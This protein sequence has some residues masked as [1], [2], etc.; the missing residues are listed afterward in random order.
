MKNRLSLTALL[1]SA[2]GLVS[3]PRQ[4]PQQAPAESARTQ[5]EHTHHADLQADIHT[6]QSLYQLESKWQTHTG[7]TIHLSTL[8]GQPQVL[9]MVYAS[10]KNACP[11][12]IADMKRIQTGSADFPGGVRY[13][14]VSID[15][16]IDTPQRLAELSR[17]S[18]LDDQ[19]LLLRGSPDDVLELAALLGVRYRKISE[20]DYAHSNLITVLNAQGEIT[21]RQQ[22]LGVD[23]AQT[24]AALEKLKA[25][26]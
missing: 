17:K 13:I 18:K 4:E 7:K 2:L 5:H 6:N 10:C 1:L 19:W 25:K 9:A 24:L 11:R 21:H 23:P 22:G 15:P 3:C 12:I 26:G 16:E 8:G 14:L 20:K